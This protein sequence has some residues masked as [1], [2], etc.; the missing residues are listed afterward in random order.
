MATDP[1]LA[2]YEDHQAIRSVLRSFEQALDS[3]VN[4][5]RAESRERERFHDTLSFLQTTVLE[6]FH[7]EE[8]ALLPPLEAK[9]GKFGSLVSVIAYDHDEVR[10]ETAKLA[11]ALAAL[12]AKATG[13]HRSEL[14]ELNRHGIFV[15]QYLGLHMAKEDSSLAETARVAL[16]E[17]GIAEVARRLEGLR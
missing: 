1:F 5:D 9:L 10:R 13:P 2:F 15:V 14:L 7:R 6:H 16:G 17:A 4:R 8:T 11:D 3:A 12:D